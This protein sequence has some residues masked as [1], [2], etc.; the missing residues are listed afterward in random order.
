M[1]RVR[2]QIEGSGNGHVRV[3]AHQLE[4]CVLV[5]QA[6]ALGGVQHAMG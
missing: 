1:G 5:D 2:D 3:A 4:C 6:V